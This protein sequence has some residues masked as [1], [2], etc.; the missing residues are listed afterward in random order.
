VRAQCGKPPSVCAKSPSFRD[1]TPLILAI[2]HALDQ[3]SALLVKPV[4]VN[5]V[6]GG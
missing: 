1:D 6:K 2:S 5:T 4:S 3:A